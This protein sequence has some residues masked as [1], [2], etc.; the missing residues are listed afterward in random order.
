MKKTL[1]FG[2][3]NKTDKSLPKLIKGKKTR[4]NKIRVKK[5]TMSNINGFQ[6]I[7]RQCLENI[8]SITVEHLEE[9]H[10]SRLI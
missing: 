9:M 4:I 5:H 10:A 3:I 6:R 7:I 2:K 8:Y 1:L